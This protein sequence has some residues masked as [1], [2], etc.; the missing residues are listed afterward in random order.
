MKSMV[1]TFQAPSGIGKGSSRPGY[2][3]RSGL[4]CWQTVRDCTYW[5]VCSF[6]LAQAKSRRRRQSVIVVA[7]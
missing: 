3:M 7:E 4:A 6:I 1:T 2:Q 5:R